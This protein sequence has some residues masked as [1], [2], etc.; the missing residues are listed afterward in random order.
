MQPPLRMKTKQPCHQNISMK[1][2]KDGNLCDQFLSTM[3]SSTT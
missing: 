1:E 2:L 3:P